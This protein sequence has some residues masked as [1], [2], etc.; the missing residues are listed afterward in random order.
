MPT[1]YAIATALSI[2]CFLVLRCYIYAE[3]KLLQYQINRARPLYV[4]PSHFPFI[5][6]SSGEA[7]HQT[8][9][10]QEPARSHEPDERH[11]RV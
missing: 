7:A 6:L 2:S 4:L 8:R 5:S 10:A 3:Y 1:A 9:L 11:Q